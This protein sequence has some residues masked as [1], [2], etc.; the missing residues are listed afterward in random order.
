[1]PERIWRPIGM[2]ES[3]VD[4]TRRR[5]A[6]EMSRG[7]IDRVVAASDAGLGLASLLG[8]RQGV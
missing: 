4:H 2:L 7:T 1:M 8:E 5:T 6:E 3:F